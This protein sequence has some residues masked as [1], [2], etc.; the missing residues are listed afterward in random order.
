MANRYSP[1]NLMIPRRVAVVN[2]F[3]RDKSYAVPPAPTFAIEGSTNLIFVSA[4]L[5]LVRPTLVAVAL[6][7][8][9]GWRR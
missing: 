1:T 8:L 2:C 9:S 7:R 4:A 6:A 3:F 5:K